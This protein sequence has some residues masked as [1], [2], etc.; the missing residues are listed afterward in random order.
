MKKPLLVIELAGPAGSGKSTL[1]KTLSE[2]DSKIQVG[3]LPNIRDV[4]NLPFI[5]WNAILLLPVFIAFYRVNNYDHLTLQQMAIMAI[6]KE[7]LR[8]IKGNSSEQRI[9]ILDQGPVYMLSELLRYGPRN[10]R[11]IASMWWERACKEWTDVLD[12][13]ICIDTS[14]AVLLE[15]IRARDKHHGIKEHPDSWAFQFL[16]RYRDAQSDVLNSMLATKHGP[17]VIQ[18]DTAQ[19]PL[20]ETIGKIL[21]ILAKKEL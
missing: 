15:R 3:V 14:D 9:I 21:P 19:V 18:I 8:Q 7:W 5:L 4:R 20:T 13:V 2:I 11:H 1:A 16:A 10:F 6:L 17:K 12:M